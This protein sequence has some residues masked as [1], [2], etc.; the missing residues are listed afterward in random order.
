M[1]LSN[2]PLCWL[3]K[4]QKL[5]TQTIVD[6]LENQALNQSFFFGTRSSNYYKK[7]EAWFNV[8]MIL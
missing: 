2:L 4:A 6:L 5:I 7:N 1:L 3:D 8:K